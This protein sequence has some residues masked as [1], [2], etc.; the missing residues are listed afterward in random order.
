MVMYGVFFFFLFF[1]FF[2]FYFC[3]QANCLCAEKHRQ[4]ILWNGTTLRRVSRVIRIGA[5]AE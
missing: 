5:Y 2:Y 4:R 3:F 1:F